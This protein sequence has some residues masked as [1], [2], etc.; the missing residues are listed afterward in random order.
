MSLLSPSQEKRPGTGESAEVTNCPSDGASEGPAE[1]TSGSVSGGVLNLA[2]GGGRLVDRVCRKLLLRQLGHLRQGTLTIRESGCVHRFGGQGEGLRATLHVRDDRFWSK[3]VLGGSLGA[4]DA[5]LRGDW[6]TD[7]LVTLLCT[8]SRN[9]AVLAQLDRGMARLL[10][11]ARV[12]MNWLQ[13]NTPAGSRRNIAAHYDLSNEFFALFLDPTMTYSSGI[14]PHP[15]ADLREASVAKYERICRKLQ[16]QPDDHLLEIGCGWGG[17]AE[18]AA[19]H[20]GCRVTATTIS[21]QQF[22]YARH[23]IQQAGLSDRV[24]LLCQDYREL[25]GAGQFDKLVSIEM[26][27]AVGERFLDA[28]F[29]TCCRLL[30]PDGMM[31]LQGITIPDHRY[32]GYRRSMDFIQRYVFPGGFLPSFGAIGQSLRRV[33]DFRFFH[34]E[35]LSPHYART[36]S[37]WRDRFWARIDEVRGLGFDE[38]FIRTWHYYLCYCE[39]GFRERLIGVSQMLLT[40]PDCRRDDLVSD[41][42]P[43]PRPVPS[44]RPLARTES[45]V[46][47]AP[48]MGS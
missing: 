20:Y 9:A 17:M 5:Y 3:A 8:L 23:R 11:P 39:A 31:L 22:E 44:S 10:R 46:P 26:I 18:H 19:A 25:R 29:A 16:L 48:T 38:R 35:E 36:L 4:A 45:D 7:D 42:L 33:T 15:K 30:K 13:R 6:E 41:P 47:L 37:E 43:S 34:S 24:T 2:S 27:E 21:K 1:G 12:A 32:D 28:Y 40:R 14:F